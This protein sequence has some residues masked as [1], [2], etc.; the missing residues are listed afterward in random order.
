MG[1]VQDQADAL[2]A[3]WMPGFDIA[4]ARRTAEGYPYVVEEGNFEPGTYG[5][6]LYDKPM[7]RISPDAKPHELQHEVEHI[8]QLYQPGGIGAIDEEYDEAAKARMYQLYGLT[9]DEA[10][11]LAYGMRPS[12]VAARGAAGDPGQV[13]A[14]LL[15]RV[16]E[17][18]AQRQYQQNLPL[19][20]ETE[21]RSPRPTTGIGG[22][23]ARER[24]RRGE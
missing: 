16:Q 8:R 21:S 22:A 17:I 7:I 15:E 19:A 9:E 1:D 2:F 11:G 4:N 18:E 24:T 12:E 14:E 13:F 23:A 10:G 6:R 20:T 5:Q 3:Q